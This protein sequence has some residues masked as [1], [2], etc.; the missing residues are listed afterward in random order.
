MFIKGCS[1]FIVEFAGDFVAQDPTTGQ[2]TSCDPTQLDG[3]VDFT[4][5]PTT[6]AHKIRWYGFPRD[7]A[8]EGKIGVV[9]SVGTATDVQYG[10]CPLHDT[11]ARASNFKAVYNN[12]FPAERVLPPFAANYESTAVAVMKAGNSGASR[13]YIVAWG[14]DTP[15]LPRPRM[16][17]ITFAIDDP[18]G[19]LST[20]QI[21][22]YVFTLP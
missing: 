21:Y 4:V 12:V 18:L 6:N 13:G 3:Q 11:L 5:D 20:S 10:V 16:M 7:P 22:E 14:I 8:D 19:H 9:P 17:R 15:T 1:Q 2:V